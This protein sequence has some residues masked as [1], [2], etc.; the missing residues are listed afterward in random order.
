MPETDLS[1]PTL[2]ISQETDTVVPAVEEKEATADTE[3]PPEP[4]RNKK[5]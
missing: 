3:H 1:R 5:Q 4:T 2:K